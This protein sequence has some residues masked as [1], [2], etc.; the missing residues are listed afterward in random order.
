VVIQAFSK[1]F[2][3]SRLLDTY[4]AASFFGTIIFFVLNSEYYTP[5]EIIFWVVFVTVAFKGFA[6]IMFSLLISLVELN[7]EED[8]LEFEKSSNKLESLVSDLAIKEASVQSQK[9]FKHE[10]K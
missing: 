3:S 2:L 10:N 5:F 9:N 7:N 4:V 6:N 8:R 1:K